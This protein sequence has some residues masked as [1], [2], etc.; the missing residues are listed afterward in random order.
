MNFAQKFLFTALIS[1]L[2]TGV[3]PAPLAA[4]PV[5]SATLCPYEVVERYPHDPGAFTQGLTVAGERVFESTGQ[6]GRSSL[7]EIELE[8]GRL[9]HNAALDRTLFGEGATYF[10]GKIYQVTWRNQRGIIYSAD[11]FERLGEFD[12][13]GEGWGLTHDGELLILS[14]GTS[15]I[16]FLDPQT[17]KVVRRME[18]TAN[19]KPVA[20]LNELEYAHGHIW[21]NLWQTAL[22]AKIN[23][24]NGNVVQWVDLEPIAR[25][26]VR[27]GI[28]NGIAWHEARGVFL[29]TGK[30]WPAMFALRLHCI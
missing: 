9:M 17:F 22:I 26:F 6:Y 25:G 2:S 20:Y 1:G 27:D 16:R 24:S 13:D 18:V 30:N 28:P 15:S 10:K 29:I 14:D 12:Y 21:A 5:T 4:G 19:N 11:G 8:T 23:P 7:R 3:I